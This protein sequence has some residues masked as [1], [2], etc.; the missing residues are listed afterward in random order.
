MG[1]ND[2]NYSNF[3]SFAEGHQ[4]GIIPPDSMIENNRMTAKL[5]DSNVY[6]MLKKGSDNKGS[7]VN[8]GLKP[9]EMF[10]QSMVY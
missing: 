4:D 7:K 8:S 2:G 6:S 10:K 1:D 3:Q 9:S 5:K